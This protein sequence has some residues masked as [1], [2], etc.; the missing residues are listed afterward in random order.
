MPKTSGLTPKQQ[1][2]VE[3]YLVDLNATQAAIRAG[4]SEHT[5]KDIGC[6]NLAKPNIAEAIAEAREKLSERTEINQEWVLKRLA[7]MADANME[8]YVRVDGE[9]LAHVDLSEVTRDQ[10]AVVTEITSDRLNTRG[11]DGETQAETTRTK[12]KISD[13]Q[14]ALEKIGRHLGMFKDKMEV[15]TPFDEMTDEQ[16]STRLKLVREQRRALTGEEAKLEMEL[17]RRE[18]TN[19]LKFYRPYDKQRDFHNA[20]ADFKE[21]LFMAGNQLG[22]TL[23]GGNEW[24]IH[25]TGRYPDWW[26]G[27]RFNRP[28]RLWAAG[29]TAESTRDN[30]QRI[31]VGP[32]QQP[33]EAGTGTIP[34]DCIIKSTPARG[35]A[36]ALDSV[37]VK[38]EAGGESVL[39]FKSYEKG[40]EK[41]Q[42]ETLDGVWF[43]EE[44]PEDI[45]TEGLTR[46]NTTGGPA[47]MTFTP[48]LGMSEV[49]RKY[50]TE[51]ED[52]ANTSRHVTQMTIYDAEH[53]T[54]EEREAIIASY[55]AHEREARAKG[56]PVLGS[57][58]I[59]PIDDELIMVEPLEIPE[60]WARIGG[61][62][63]G[64][65]HPFAAVEMVHD[66]DADIV[67]ITKAH[68]VKEQTPIFH[69]AALKAWG[70]WLP[71]SWPRDGR[72]ET[73][74][75]AGKALAEQYEAQGLKML[76]NHA[77]F[78]DKSVSVEAGLMDMLDRMQTGRF[79]VFRNLED[80][81]SEFRLYH[82]KDGK[83]VKEYDDL[84][85]ASRYALMMLRHAKT[86][87][88]PFRR[89][90]PQGG[91][92]SWMSY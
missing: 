53:Y 77:Q 3:E 37:V 89:P 76:H 75:G 70:D 87:P 69:A 30:P 33:G 66:R 52:T 58:R 32:P 86:K 68:R 11:S 74:E 43:D 40:R 46:T 72:R 24:A 73:L 44:P 61:M 28:V 19:R 20:G 62:D 12:I 31:L 45:Y 17:L 71:W 36:H 85:A 25:L 1:R 91:G 26:Q 47:I 2:F 88:K 6:E 5:A 10:F 63:F 92:R 54:P 35:T 60:I 90:R 48:L 51:N 79:K 83:V 21:R 38:H 82:R 67:Y 34:Q 9:G 42:G 16:I 55:P 41:W 27:Y 59:F 7:R 8:D 57:G 14:A 56:V 23:A 13:Q 49:V 4:Y 64:W 84:M 80:W 50:L 29:V 81:F 18:K 22:K 39:S 15:S 65:D 78:E